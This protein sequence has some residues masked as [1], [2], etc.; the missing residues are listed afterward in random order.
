M[1]TPCLAA[2]LLPLSLPAQPVTHLATGHA[3]LGLRY[4]ASA[5]PR[6]SLTVNSADTGQSY[7]SNQVVLVATEATRFELPP[8]TPFG[9]AGEPLWILPQSQFPGMLYLGLSA[10]TIP[11]GTFSG[12]LTLALKRVEMPGQTNL[13]TTG[14][15]YA[16][17]TAGF[18]QFDV[19]MDSANGITAADA[20]P[21]T[22]PGHAHYNWGFSAAGLWHVTL[23]AGGRVTGESTNSFSD[24]TTLAFHVLPLRPFEQWQA[25]NWPP[26]TPR[27]II[28]PEAD[29]SG[30]GVPNLVEY[31]LGRS[32]TAPGSEGLPTASI[33]ESG[34]QRYGALTYTHMKYATDV[35][36]EVAAT[37]SLTP[38]VW[39]PLTILHSV[40]DLG[41]R[42]RIT[43][44]DNVPLSAG[45]PRFYQLQ[46]RMN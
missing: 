13:I 40:Q 6:L 24:E 20:I 16:W 46:V 30:N 8:G 1:K 23:Q 19:F 33:V 7:T 27:A 15:F 38:P 32:P 41:D 37:S 5:T 10:A 29:P 39:Q 42:L 26:A 34:G 2:L 35:S 12:P 22:P 45:Q 36:C 43:V 31:T 14:R 17:Q 3:D 9:E 44:R 18:G 21:L 28:G 11:A 4:S 25:T